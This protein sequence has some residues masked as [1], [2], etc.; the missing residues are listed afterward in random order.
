M[1]QV[2]SVHEFWRTNM[3]L[4]ALCACAERA[5]GT[6]P[7]TDDSFPK[8][9][10]LFV[11]CVQVEPEQ[12]SSHAGS[13]E[14]LAE[15]MPAAGPVSPVSHVEHSVIESSSNPEA[16]R[17]AGADPASAAVAKALALKR[18]MSLLTGIRYAVPG[19]ASLQSNCRAALSEL[20]PDSCDI[21]G[22]ESEPELESPV[23]VADQAPVPP[24]STDP[25][26]PSAQ[27]SVGSAVA[28][29]HRLD[30]ASIERYRVQA[31]EEKMV[32]AVG[33]VNA[34]LSVI[35]GFSIERKEKVWRKR[36]IKKEAPPPTPAEEARLSRVHKVA[37]T[38]VRK[39]HDKL[40]VRYGQASEEQKEALAK[41]CR[42]GLRNVLPAGEDVAAEIKTTRLLNAT[43]Q[44]LV[45]YLSGLGDDWDSM[46][47]ASHLGP[48]N[49]HE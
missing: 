21:S 30:A 13:Q 40:W 36:K 39:L 8:L 23:P 43:T 27:E 14:L 4:R 22:A 35:G 9:H 18:A 17:P 29:N 10:Q 24:D 41:N 33:S 28:A 6:G 16:P 26:P 37:D 44:K 38:I 42:R 2:C 20:T 49:V 19:Y 7:Q 25:A 48:K 1:A 31:E 3:C 45:E 34:F 5:R 11:S 46:I 47:A 12:G 15:T 32:L